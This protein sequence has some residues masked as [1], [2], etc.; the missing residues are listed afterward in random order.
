MAYTINFTGVEVG[1]TP[2][3]ITFDSE[4]IILDDSYFDLPDIDEYNRFIGWTNSATGSIIKRGQRVYGTEQVINLEAIYSP[5]PGVDIDVYIFE[6]CTAYQI[7]YAGENYAPIPV[8]SQGTFLGWQSDRTN[9]IYQ[10]GEI[11]AEFFEDDIY[12]A[13]V[14]QDKINYYK[15]ADGWQPIKQMYKKTAD[16]WQPAKS[17]NYKTENGWR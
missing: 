17:V 4:Y 2:A 11:I 6:N 1:T 5:D 10:P 15:T 14:W 12:F 16:G 3:S 8:E 7:D 13:A 9:A